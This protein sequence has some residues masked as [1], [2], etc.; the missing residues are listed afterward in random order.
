[1]TFDMQY[2]LSN[3]YKVMDLDKSLANIV[4]N[5]NQTLLALNIKEVI[6]ILSMETGIQISKF[7][8]ITFIMFYYI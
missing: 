5:E 1:M 4:I 6:Y 2:N 7:S 3:S 8:G